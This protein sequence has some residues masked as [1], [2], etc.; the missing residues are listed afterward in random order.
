[1]SNVSVIVSYC[2]LDKRFIKP[3]LNQLLIFSDDIVVVCF[4]KL[5]N[6]TH[7]ELGDLDDVRKLSPEKIKTLCLPFVQGNKSRH[8]HNLARWEG[9]KYT[10]HDRILFLDADEIPEGEVFK[11]ILDS[12]AL[13]KFDAVDFA[14]HW[15][16]R[17]A[18]NQAKQKEQCGLLIKRDLIKEEHMFTEH[19]RWSYRHVR[20]IKYA[21]MVST[22]QGPILHHYS[23]TRT[24]EEML[25]KVSAWGHMNDKDWKSLIEKEFTH[26]F[27]GSD[28]VH[29]YSYNIVPDHFNIGI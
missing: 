6:G 12:N 14:C 29:G 28:F 8:Y 23:W 2:S 19:E 9:V 11:S 20:G 4:D 15:Y 26:D 18:T 3:L 1:M 13:E 17:S 7:E 16:F 25:T 24:K 21:P 5:L 27:N 22:P 10:K